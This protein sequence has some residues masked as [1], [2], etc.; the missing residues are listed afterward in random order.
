MRRWLLACLCLLSTSAA[1]CDEPPAPEHGFRVVESYPHDPKA[2]TQGLLYLGGDLWESTGRYGE[3]SLRR[4]RRADGEVIEQRRLSRRLF[5][6][7]LTH[8][9]GR[10]FQ[11]TW[12]NG[13]AMV[14]DADEMRPLQTLSYPGE[15]WGLT[16]M[17]DRLIMSDGSARL[18][19][20]QPKDFAQ[21]GSVVVRDACK[22]VALLNELEFIDGLVFANVW[23][24]ERIAV[25]DP[26]N[27]KVKAWLN[28]KGLLP[29]HLA[30][31]VDVLNGI[32]WDGR[33]G[34]LTVTGKNWPRLFV[35]QPQPELTVFSK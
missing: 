29:K 2:F 35:I 6:E 27:G 31:N 24:S 16:T 22:P 3:S 32:A 23:K 5:A 4:V 17:G 21:T 18:R 12:K 30:D 19:F 7:G 26:H 34:H 11:L 28:L 25:I 9:N 10:L 33:P 8:W 13:V 14:W 1:A 20:I 15:G